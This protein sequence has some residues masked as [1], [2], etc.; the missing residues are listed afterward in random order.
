MLLDAALPPTSLSAIPT[1]AHAAESMGFNTLWSAETVHDPFLPGPLVA[2]H[3]QKL[4]FGTAIAVSFG[5]SPATMAYTAWDLAQTSRGR[6][7]L[8]L[9]TQVRAHIER[10]FGLPWPDS[11]LDKLREQVA[12][13]RAFWKTWQTGERLNYRAEYYQLTLMSPFFNPGP[14]DFPEIP[15][16]IAGVNSGMARLAGEVADGFLVH[17]FHS[18]RYLQEVI[19][20]AIEHG[21]SKTGRTRDV[22]SV[23]VTAFIITSS[24]ERESARQQ[25]AFYASTPSYRAVMALHGWQQE[26]ESLSALASRAKWGEMPGLVSDEMLDVFATFATQDELPTAL[27]NRYKGLA[28]RLTLY[29]PFVP[30]ERDAFWYN[31]IKAWS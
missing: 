5:R 4:K 19:L 13:I 2:E 16:Y 26:A 3:T 10:R 22:V 7:I 11:P 24:E 14:I 27:L 8:G 29:I 23:S 1:I 31:L 30:G 15:I 12:A 21:A 28:D 25:I 20:P 9:G 18:P 6:F 17:P